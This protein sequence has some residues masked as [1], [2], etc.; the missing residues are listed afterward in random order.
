MGGAR[1]FSFQPL[2]SCIAR[3]YCSAISAVLTRLDTGFAFEWC[4]RLTR[5]GWCVSV[6]CIVQCTL[7]KYAQLLAAYAA[8]SKTPS[9]RQD[10]LAVV[11]SCALATAHPGSGLMAAYKAR[12]KQ[13]SPLQKG[14]AMAREQ[15]VTKRRV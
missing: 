6:R 5:D 7:R 9:N 2:G 14:T 12:R 13:Q 3:K 10:V 11:C 8:C 4:T 15:N 1:I